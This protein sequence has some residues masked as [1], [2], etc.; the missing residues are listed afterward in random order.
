M[1]SN[2]SLIKVMD[3]QGTTSIVT[4][5]EFVNYATRGGVFNVKWTDVYAAQQGGKGPMVLND[6]I[7]AR[8]KKS[9]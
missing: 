9:N 6:N 2:K 4:G 1:S 5:E 3:S 8:Y 7:N